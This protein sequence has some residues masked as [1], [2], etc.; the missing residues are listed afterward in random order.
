MS[1]RSKRNKRKQYRYNKNQFLNVV[2][3]NCQVCT[4]YVN[5]T[6]CYVE[7]YR[8]EP[9][10]FVNFCWKR[11]RKLVKWPSSI[12]VG[13]KI[14]ADTI[15][16]SGVCKVTYSDECPLIENCYMEFRGQTLIVGENSTAKKKSNKK[17]RTKPGKQKAYI[18][19][20]YATFFCDKREKWKEVIDTILNTK[21]DKQEEQMQK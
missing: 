20:A 4:D 9:R 19:E 16:A 13:K 2:C 5:P 8:N 15:C 10:K 21:D 7:L 3:N 12:E 11:L 1:K 18:C 17:M 6:F 14:F